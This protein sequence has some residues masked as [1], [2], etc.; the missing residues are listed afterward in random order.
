[1][2][3]TQDM[4][5]EVKQ[6]LTLAPD[7]ASLQ[8]LL[9]QLHLTLNEQQEQQ[10]EKQQESSKTE[11]CVIPFSIDG[12]CYLLPAIVIKSDDA[13]ST[14]FVV[15][16]ITQTTIPCSAFLSGQPCTCTTH[17][18]TIPTDELLPMEALMQDDYHLDDCVWVKDDNSGLYVKA[19]VEDHLATGEWRVQIVSTRQ[20]KTVSALIPVKDLLKEESPQQMDNDDEENNEE[21]E[22]SDQEYGI[23]IL[24]HH[25]QQSENW[26]SWQEHTT[27]FGAKM[28][29][30]MGYVT[31]QGLGRGN[32]GRVDP[33][34]ATKRRAGDRVGLGSLA[35]I[36]SKKETKVIN[37]KKQQLKSIPRRAGHQDMFATMNKMLVS[38]SAT[39]TTA[40]MSSSSTSFKEQEHNIATIGRSTAD[41]KSSQR[42]LAKLQTKIAGTENELARAMEAIRRNKGTLTENQFKDQAKLIGQ[43]LDGLKAQASTLQG[44]I[45]R[46]T[47]REKMYTF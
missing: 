19:T 16:P 31:G 45:K 38:D 46:T 27:G 8:S 3:E 42:D 25:Q 6:L 14:V 33:V 11:S 32:Q 5:D 30:K 20:N 9:D 13:H 1:M 34:P 35:G 44:S 43:R 40:S 21:D 2:E 23:S 18:M 15:T 37:K 17:G 22:V 4:I 7:D 41:P 36:A 29:A 47:D 10:Q 26:A 28:L 12:H 39:S 24:H